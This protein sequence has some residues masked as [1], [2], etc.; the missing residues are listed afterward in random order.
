M[1]RYQ[2]IY[3]E[4]KEQIKDGKMEANMYLPSESEYMN[5]YHVSR[6]TIRKALNL[7]LHDGFIVKE[8]GKGSKVIDLARIAFPISGLTSFKELM[9]TMHGEVKTDVIYFEKR[10]VRAEEKE[11]MFMQTGELFAI[12][13]VRSLDGERV[14]LDSDYLNAQIVPNVTKQIAQDSL[15]DYIEHKL[16]LKISFAKK[17]ITVIPASPEEKKVLDL[18]KYD[19]LVCIKSYV[20]LEDATLFQYTISKHRPDKFRFVDFARRTQL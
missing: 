3:T 4:L 20:Y 14:I 12:Q 9:N 16:Q 17:E 18:G 19:M 10:E 1:S 8:Q 5:T 13:R 11:D 6:D 15:Y 2:E 7:L